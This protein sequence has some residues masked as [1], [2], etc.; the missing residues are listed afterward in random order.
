MQIVYGIEA[1]PILMELPDFR[2]FLLST[3][4]PL[5]IDENIYVYGG[6]KEANEFS[7][8]LAEA[9]LLEETHLFIK[10]NGYAGEDFFDYGFHAEGATFLYAD[11]LSAFKFTGGHEVQIEMAL[12]QLEEHLV[13][14]SAVG[15]YFIVN[16]YTDLVMGIV[17]AYEVKVEFL[18]LDKWFK[19]I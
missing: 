3:V 15:I 12:V 1:K 2:S 5:F 7:G 19:K 16:H 14:K 13:F 9:E 11:S 8:L 17:K 10:T 6:Q 18:N 4:P